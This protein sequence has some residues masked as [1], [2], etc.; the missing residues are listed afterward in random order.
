[1][2]SHRSAA[3]A[4]VGG[5]P[6]GAAL[7]IR[8]ADRGIEAVLFERLPAPRWRAAGVYT[9]PLTRI[10]LR[11]LGLPESDVGR[12]LRPIGGMVVRTHDDRAACRLEYPP[13]MHACGLDRGNLER[14]LLDR[15]RRAGAQ[16]HEGAVVR[17]VDLSGDRPLL[18]VSL[19]GGGESW[20]VG[21]VV[22]ADGPASL[23]A[24]SSGVALS[25]RRFRRAGL[26]AHRADPAALPEGVAMDAEMVI[27]GGWYLGIAPV[28]GARVNLGLVI[29]ESDLRRGLAGGGGEAGPILEGA[30]TRLPGAR[31][32]WASAPQTDSVQV[33]LPLAHR[34][35][36]AAGTNFMLVGDAAGFID[37][38][39]GDGLQRSF[40]SA[41]R[42][43]DAVAGWSRG[44]PGALSDYDRHLRARFR[45]KDILSWLL[46]A[47]LANPPLTARA[48]RRLDR[49]PGLRRTFGMA[50]ADLV[51]A[52][53][54]L[55]PRFVRRL[56]L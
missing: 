32:S 5:G 30:V 56:L 49:D 37:P 20:S 9:S 11:E 52:S 12:L 24:R 47:F 14:A 29:G 45:S 16:V 2:S 35:R 34:V 43:A 50:L 6:A 17:S 33:A 10:R 39:S 53:R 13:P 54:V 4:I 25:A 23:V 1:V 19:A 38:L 51:P 48:V 31:R 15:A 36:R 7:A 41:A 27:G 22:G 40:A 28:P 44:D 3:V 42:A 26:T 18:D 46:Q 55:D 21:V 8:L